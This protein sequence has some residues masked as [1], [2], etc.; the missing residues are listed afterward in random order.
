[1]TNTN[2]NVAL[3]RNA[4]IQN[5]GMVTY[6]QGLSKWN[7]DFESPIRFTDSIKLYASIEGIFSNSRLFLN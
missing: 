7:G 3:S 1:M 6:F 5:I 4:L 2:H